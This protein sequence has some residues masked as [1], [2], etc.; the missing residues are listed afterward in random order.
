MWKRAS[1]GD[2]HVSFFEVLKLSHTSDLYI[3]F[4]TQSGPCRRVRQGK[5]IVAKLDNHNFISRT[6]MIE[7]ENVELA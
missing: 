1:F 7:E 3:T 4:M 6:H 5:I 2:V